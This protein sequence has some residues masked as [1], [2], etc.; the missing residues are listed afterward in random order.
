MDERGFLNERLP[1]DPLYWD[2]TDARPWG[3]YLNQSDERYEEYRR[4]GERRATDRLL[5][6]MKNRVQPL[7]GTVRLR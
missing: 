2:A 3:T 7:S 5:T 4:L 1:G 6:Q